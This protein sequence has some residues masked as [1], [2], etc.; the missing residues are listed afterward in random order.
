MYF[1]KK[2]EIDFIT[3]VKHISFISTLVYT[4]SICASGFIQHFLGNE[5]KPQKV[6]D[7]FLHIIQFVSFKD[8]Y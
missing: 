4:R 1:L 8:N 3:L 5:V 6:G 7:H 2:C